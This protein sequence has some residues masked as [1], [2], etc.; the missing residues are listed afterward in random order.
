VWSR[1]KTPA[2]AQTRPSPNANFR[3]KAYHYL[4]ADKGG[5]LAIDG[6][7]GSNWPVGKDGNPPA[8]SHPFEL[9]SVFQIWPRA[10]RA[11]EYHR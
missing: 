6:A 2:P 8:S 3:I 10:R 4:A 11:D 7:P 1:G 9:G 5:A